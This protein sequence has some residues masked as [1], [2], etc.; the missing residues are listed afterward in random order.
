MFE[1]TDFQVW[2]IKFEF[3]I[4]T[5]F[6]GLTSRRILC[7]QS[8]LQLPGTL[9]DIKVMLTTSKSP[10]KKEIESKIKK[11]QV[12]W[13]TNIHHVNTLVSV[14]FT[15][16]ILFSAL[17]VQMLSLSL[18]FKDS[19]CILCVVG[20]GGF[21]GEVWSRLPGLARGGGP[22]QRNDWGQ[23][24]SQSVSRLASQSEFSQS[25]SI[26]TY[27]RLHMMSLLY[28][29]SI[30]WCHCCNITRC[31]QYSKLKYWKHLVIL[32]QFNFKYL[33]Y[34]IISNIRT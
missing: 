14:C 32:Q 31:S 13:L 15:D 21:T 16:P 1:C 27:D 19:L 22:V 26:A 6:L 7:Y 33:L 34:V 10:G 17:C 3:W 5:Y 4:V 20:A 28:V 30:M 25:H 23:S 8:F 24:V 9:Q 18:C 29:T 2:G 12:C 11:I